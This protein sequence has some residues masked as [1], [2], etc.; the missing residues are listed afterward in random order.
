MLSVSDYN[1]PFLCCYGADLLAYSFNFIIECPLFVEVADL[2]SIGLV[3]EVLALFR[4]QCLPLLSYLLHD[5]K[6]SHFRVVI[7]NQGSRL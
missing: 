6:G 5:L 3:F 2:V 7:H 1:L 4:S